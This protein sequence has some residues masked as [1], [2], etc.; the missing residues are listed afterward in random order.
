MEVT[1]LRRVSRVPATAQAGAEC[2]TACGK[3]DRLHHLADIAVG[4]NDERI[5]VFVGQ[6]EGQRGQAAIS[7]T[8]SGASTSVR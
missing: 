4:Q 2:S 1:T 3:F 5:A 6:I 7:C 8:E